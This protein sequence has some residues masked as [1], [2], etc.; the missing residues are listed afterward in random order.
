MMVSY[1]Y[2]T[3]LWLWVERGSLSMKWGQHAA[4]LPDRWEFEAELMPRFRL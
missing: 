1:R 3:I 2:G 4:V